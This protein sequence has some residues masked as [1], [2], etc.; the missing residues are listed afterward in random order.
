MGGLAVLQL[1][2]VVMCGK[3]KQTWDTTA[4]VANLESVVNYACPGCGHH[5]SAWPGTGWSVA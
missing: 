1:P 4:V 5:G 2:A 3:C